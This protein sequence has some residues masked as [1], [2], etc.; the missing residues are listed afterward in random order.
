MSSRPEISGLEVVELIGS[1][2]FSRVY[3]AVQSEFGREVAV[4]VLRIDGRDEEVRYSFQR[5]CALTGRLTGHPN[6]LTVLGSGFVPCD[7][8]P[9]LVLEYCP[10]GTLSQRLSDDG[11]LS[12]PDVLSLGISL[13]GALQ[14]AHRH[15]VIHRDVKP[16]NV[17]FG[18]SGNPV[19]ADF[20]VAKLRGPD[21]SSVTS[22][23]LTPLHAAP[24][25]LRQ[26]R[27]SSSSD[28]YSLAST[29]HTTLS[30][31]APF[32][33]STDSPY[34]VM[35]RA[36]SEPVPRIGRRDVS[37][38][39][40]ALLVAAMAKEPEDRPTVS[41][42]AA[43]LRRCG[44]RWSSAVADFV[45]LEPP[46]NFDPDVTT[47][48]IPAADLRPSAAAVSLHRTRRRRK[49]NR[50]LLAGAAAMV[51]LASVAITWVVTRQ[52]DAD[53]AAEGAASNPSST[54][55]PGSTAGVEPVS[56]LRDGIQTIVPISY[57]YVAKRQTSYGDRA[58]ELEPLVSLLGL[59]AAPMISDRLASAP[60][61]NAVPTVFEWASTNPG[62]GGRC[63]QMITSPVLLEATG[64]AMSLSTSPPTVLTITVTAFSDE[65]KANEF[66]NVASAYMGI[67]EGECAPA[68]TRSNG[69]VAAP[70]NVTLGHVDP[71]VDTPLAT[72]RFTHL[73]LWKGL[74][75]FRN[76]DADMLPTQSGYTAVGIVASTVIVVAA[77]SAD[78]TVRPAT[79]DRILLIAAS[80]ARV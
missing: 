54:D 58:A 21:T 13:A 63:H 55:A 67:T 5:E 43:E 47:D 52:V 72:E 26:E 65:G 39:L 28:L 45:V 31:H 23:G 24:E 80:F 68:V 20:G 42:F 44:Q 76:R 2:G 14:S 73:N 7:A 40:E 51:L 30:G 64:E 57:P 49:A 3:R 17:L 46:S 41:E 77:G 12:I 48:P 53:S 38:D 69:L 33:S 37:E 18:R 6:V 70:G 19:L 61:L 29:L 15:G 8:E 79:F 50:S 11:P 59:P 78:E 32:G 66:F 9:Y 27:A 62:S 34:S 71:G 10:G 1:G 74:K 25:V 36:V 16:Q 75:P 4:K 22:F 35:Q 60:Q 56:A